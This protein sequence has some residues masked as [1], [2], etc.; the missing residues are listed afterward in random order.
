MKKS[1][2]N[3]VYIQAML[4]LFVCGSATA[5]TN[6]NMANTGTTGGSPFAI[7][8]PAT[9]FYNFYDSGGPG[10]SYSPGANGNV[11]FVPSNSA[12]HRIRASFTS[13]V[14]EPGWDAFYI[15][16]SNTVG[17]NQVIGPDGVTNGGFPA[18]NWQTVSPGIIT[19]NTGIAAVGANAA[20]ALTFQFRSDASVE[21]AGWS[22]IINEVPK[23]VC[24]MTAPG[25]I[26]VNT[27]VGST[28]CFVNVNTAI[29]SF[30]PGGCNAGYQLQYRINGGSPTVVVPPGPINIQ[31]PVGANVITWELVNPCGLAVI[32]S[33]T[34]MITVIDNT[35]P[36]I[37]CPGNITFNLS[38]GECF[39][40]YSYSV[41]CTDNCALTMSGIVSH[42]ID[43]DNGNSGIMFNVVNLGFTPMTLTEFGPSLDVGTWNMQVYYKPGSW[44]GSQGNPADWTLAGTTNVVSASPAVGTPIPAFG[45]TLAAGQTMGIYLTATFGSPMNYTGLGL[46]GTQRQFDDGKLRVSSQPGAGINYP[47]NGA[48]LNRAYNGYVK[49]DAQ[50]TTQAVLQSGIP[51]GGQ[52]PIGTTNN[53]YKCTDAAG[54]MSFCNF[55]VT[56]NPV[57]NPVQ[58]LVCNDLV[59]IALGEDCTETVGADQVLEGGPYKCFDNYLVEVDKTP[60]Y[61]N[62]PWVPAV[63]TSADIGKTY[64]IRVTDTDNW[65]RCSG[66]IKIQDNLEPFLD[67]FAAEAVI[68]CNFPTSPTFFQNTD[69][70]VKYSPQNLPQNV[71]DN[72]TRTYELPVNLPANATINDVDLGVKISGDAFQFNL[73]IEI[74]SPLGVNVRTW[75][76]VGGCGTNPVWIRFDD[77]GAN[78]TTCAALSS[79]QKTQIPFG[80]GT[81]STFDGQPANGTWKVRISDV[82]GNGDVSLIESVNLFLNVNGNFGTGLPN[83]LTIP[84]VTQIAAQS[85]RVPAGLMDFCSDVTLSYVDQSSPLPCNTGYSGQITRQWTAK[86]AS[87]NQETCNQTILLIRPTFDDIQLPPNYDF[88]DEPGFE[89]GGAYPTPAWIE[90]QGQQGFPMAFDYSGACQINYTFIDQ[91]VPYC[92]GSFDIVRRWSIVDPCDLNNG[93]LQYNQ[94]IHVR[95]FDGPTIDCPA[96]VTVTTDPFACCGTANLPDV[97]VSD[98][99]SRINNVSA[100]IQTV[101]PFTQIITNTFV[102]VGSLGSFPGNNL[103][104]PDTL[105]IFGNTPCLPVGNHLVTY[106]IQDGCGN[107]STCS[108]ELCVKDYSPPAPACDEFTVVSIGIDDPNDCYSPTNGCEFAGVTWVKAFTFDDGSYDNCSAIKFTIRRAAPY[109][110][111]IT[112]LNSCEFATATAESD[113]IKFYCCEVG[114]T[115]KVILRVYQLDINGNIAQLPDGTPIYN[116]CEVMVEV[117]DKLKPVCEPPLN[118]TVSCENFDPSLWAYGK[119]VVYDN[120][121]LDST[122]MYQNQKG[123]THTVNYSLFDTLCQRGTITRTF[124]V[125]DCRGF[126]SQCTQRVVVNY[127]QD[128][129]IKFPNDVI[130]TTCNG[131]GV[132]GVPTFFGEDC[133]LLGVSFEDEVYTVVPDAC[134]K[135]E[136]TWKIINWCTYNPNAQPQCITVP[137]PNPNSISN[138]PTNLPGPIV[139]APGTQG[140][141][142]P[143]V[144]KVNPND[145]TSTNFS[146]FWNANAN[147][148]SY[149]QI[150]KVVDTQAPIAVCPP[151][152]VEFC[153][154]S[155][156]DPLLWNETYWWDAA[157]NTHDLCEGQA[158]LTISATD[159]CSG[160]NVSFRYLLILDLDGDNVME[161][162]VSSTNPPDAGQVRYNNAASQNYAGGTLRQFDK[163]NVAANQKYRFGLQTTVNGSSVTASVRWNTLLSPSNYIIP[164]LPY[165]KHKIKWFVS[166]GCG[167]ETVC[168]YQFT[169]KD[170]KAPTVVC[171]NGL[172]ANVMSNGLTLFISDFLFDAYDNCTPIDYLKFGIRKSDTGTGFPVDAN[173]NPQTS[174]TFDCSE[175]GTQPVEVWGI[176]K[177]GNAD[178]CET[179]IIIQDNLSNCPNV[180]GMASVAGLLE[181]EMG[182]G[183]E[184]TDVELAGQNPAGPSFSHFGTTN[185]E[186]AYAFN[187][188]VPMFSNYTV[189]PT[190]D[191][192]PLNGVSTYDLLLISKHILG[193]Q[194]LPTPYKMI[195]ADANMSGSI[196]NFDIL[197]LRKLILGIYTDLPAA[198]SWRFV[199]KSFNFPNTQNPF[200]TTFPENKSL[201]DI[202]G[203][204]MDD[205]FMAVKVGD[206]NNSAIA[207]ALMQTDDRST[208]TLLFD[209][210]DRKV[211]AGE[212]VDVKFKATEAMAGYQFTLGYTDL[213]VVNITPGAGMTADQFAVFAEE[214]AITTSWY[215]QESTPANELPEFTI[216][217]RAKGA[218]D[219]SKML[220][221]SSRITKAEAYN[222]EAERN[223][224]A[225][226]FNSQNG[227]TIS[228][229]GF[230]LYQ[231]QPN[232]FVT[233]TTIG[234][235]LPEDAEA[236]LSVFDAEG[237]MVHRQKGRFAKGYNAFVVEKALVN[238]TGILYY[239]LETELG[240]ATR[241]MIQASK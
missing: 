87:G 47:F 169:V 45:I 228:G 11:T 239:T 44:V 182:D 136:R 122:K 116:E 129:F 155:A 231:N 31:A 32:S 5:Q 200:Q 72:Q 102:V 77:E 207:N 221:V 177:A 194:T 222:N 121:C 97:I 126:T 65:N 27:G 83:G 111:C 215:K 162:V 112:S 107:T 149:K 170:C 186:G 94:I 203:N 33:A 69:V 50:A 191:D 119:P 22:A 113:S 30:D 66:D 99:C 92:D 100:T 123:L 220:H 61:G 120:C 91:T 195:A 3:F 28:T 17:T 151:S 187:N 144:V 209:V 153:D 20:E 148:Y 152:P 139:S 13:F 117:Q 172:T 48:S 57:P 140:A 54:N 79:N 150:I 21:F 180:N 85:F 25:A 219:L 184:E 64:K 193:I 110:T 9:C 236:T 60:P 68:P 39:E 167:N 58:S 12:T 138:H 108:F 205:N 8:P 158:D 98:N 141:W 225:F 190:K 133:E 130:V 189:T 16:N 76:Q 62:G 159:L 95:D 114:T 154:L 71:V 37:T 160:A 188:A 232:P 6:V 198:P 18:G 173:G 7:S 234:F 49:Y 2:L 29:P 46:A 224:V 59:F 1:N 35:V 73:R 145:A 89:C 56:V 70:T 115:Q 82:D 74:E 43:F 137:N 67:C 156:N 210:D 128:Y 40:S 197:E 132:Y 88:V 223:T 165:G 81:L 23:A 96:N 192:N 166:D 127:E 55:T 19:A 26:S 168:E 214:K 196:T 216:R 75:E 135:I 34:Q 105:A 235:H 229:V 202:H 41:P 213:D 230:E 63:L 147:C 226:R 15:F 10:S 24:T 161:T 201:A 178:F 103:S 52:F 179:Y 101:D 174:V 93:L 143:T 237:K 146:I 125:F 233:K 78:S 80:V 199:D 157:C 163:R 212:V 109:S 104:L 86:D 142:A 183:L 42:P 38:D 206:V 36:T 118:V 124:R 175:V 217:F 53:V 51:S 227:S 181:T 171:V 218:G 176:D 164:E 14:L 240:S 90:G 4:F 238:S 208:G 84:P 241:K 211:K 131:T 134:F 185:Q 204:Q 106:T